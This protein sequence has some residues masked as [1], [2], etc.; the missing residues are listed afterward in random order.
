MTFHKNT[1]IWKLYSVNKDDYETCVWYMGVV[2]EKFNHIGSLSDCRLSN[3]IL[4]LL[5]YHCNEPM[6][7]ED[8]KM[9]QLKKALT[10]FLVLSMVLSLCA[11]SQNT[12][13]NAGEPSST[14]EGTVSAISIRAIEGD[15]VVLDNDERFII[16]R[17]HKQ[18]LKEKHMEFMKRMV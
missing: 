18:S 14:Y 2:K 17:S 12:G 3:L 9:Y 10:T 7:K 4:I 13:T 6:I 8:F 11:C 15:E 5:R 16:A 1:R